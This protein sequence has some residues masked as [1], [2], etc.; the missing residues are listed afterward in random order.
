MREGGRTQS[1]S[2]CG[3]S[4]SP[5]CC[6]L[7]DLGDIP[8]DTLMPLVLY[9]VCMACVLAPRP[10]FG[11]VGGLTG[12]E[13]ERETYSAMQMISAIREETKGGKQKEEA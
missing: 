6:V 13:R 2:V 5:S 7:N 8:G 3:P 4:R 12:R 9:Y 1:Q 11:G 10:Y